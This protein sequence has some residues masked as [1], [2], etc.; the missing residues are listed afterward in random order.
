M[1]CPKCKHDNSDDVKICESCGYTFG[2]YENINKQSK[3]SK[4]AVFSFILS[5]PTIYISIFTGIPS[6]LYG[7]K[8]ILK[9]RKSQGKLKGKTLAKAAI[10]VSLVLLALNRVLFMDAAPIR[11][12]YTINYF[13]TPYLLLPQSYST[14]ISIGSNTNDHLKDAL[15]I[16]LSNSDVN[17]IRL[18]N[19]IF[20]NQDLNTISQ[21]ILENESTI[22]SIWKKSS[23]ERY[24]FAMLDQYRKISELPEGLKLGKIPEYNI[25]LRHLSSIYR[26]YICLQASKGNYQEALKELKLWD[27]INKKMSLGSLDVITKQANIASFNLEIN[28]ANF[29][30][31]NADTPT[32]ILLE[33]KPLIDSYSPQVHSSLKYMII[34]EY[35]KF[36]QSLSKVRYAPLLR[37]NSTLKLQKNIYERWIAIEGDPNKIPEL[38]VWPDFYPDIPAVDYNSQDNKLHWLYRI[39]NPFGSFMASK[40]RLNLFGLYLMKIRL[41]SSMDMIKIVL[42]KRLTAQPNPDTFKKVGK[43]QFNPEKKRIYTII[44]D[45]EEFELPINPEVLH[46]SE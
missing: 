1:N 20:T 3:T 43:Y 2:E 4:L 33:L 8:S 34:A 5:I 28:A 13:K 26:A 36:K 42:N 9:I 11:N 37:Y 15:G 41:I 18:I 7:Y 14:L 44:P 12:D 22:E 24:T 6:I 31:N 38:K 16:G 45:G 27:S 21:D 29:I 10:V 32:D 30:I 23:L 17:N 19:K 46:L 25:V 35:L 39:Y 40:T